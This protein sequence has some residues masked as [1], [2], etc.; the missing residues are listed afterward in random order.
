MFS[1]DHLQELLSFD[2]NGHG[3]VSL[4]LDT[5]CA[6]QPMETIK[7]QVK[8]LL[9]QLNGAYTEDA[10]QVEH[11]LDLSYDWSKPGLALFSSAENDFFRAYPVA[12]AFRNRLRV[13]PRPYVKPLAHLLDHYAYYGVIL[14]DK[15]GAR[16]FVYNL[17]ELLATEGVMG[18]EVRKI[19]K[20]S[21]ASTSG[22]RGG[23]RGEDGGS[24]HEEEVAQRNMRDSA[25]AAARFFAKQPIR[26]LFLGGTSENV[27]Q[28][29]ELLPKKLQS[30]LAG[31]FAID[32]TAGEHE[33]R[34]E[35]LALLK[36]ANAE[37]EDR[38]L[39]QLVTASAKG[40][41]AAVGLDDTLQAIS[42]KRVQT[43]II[44]DGFRVP[45]YVH[46]EAGFV[47]AN[48]ARSPMSESDLTEVPDVIDSAVAY[49][50]SQ[51]GHVE[52]ITDNPKLEGIGR[53]GAIL[54]Y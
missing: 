24:R 15:V 51:G 3:V 45:G 12:V 11:Y 28:F 26:R 40:S 6:Q 41:N 30:T 36:R 54:R 25:T 50:M 33:V 48:L 29:R 23:G 1:Q 2:A 32:M 9:K 38:L 16:F 47:V 52:V 5:D 18:E 27:A 17:G 37:R 20:G 4:Y 13:G 19:K 43:L 7:L 34:D 10:A 44:S 35:T 8:G 14:I 21:G 49:T 53:I 31:T 42:D 39:D 46:D 22:V